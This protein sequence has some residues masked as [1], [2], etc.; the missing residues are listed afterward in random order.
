V[1][2]L[3]ALREWQP[4]SWLARNLRVKVLA[5]LLA[6]ASW[7]VVVY[8]ANPPDSRQ[9]LVHVQQDAQQLP[10]RYVLAH[11]ISDITVRIQGTR[12]HV[13]AFTASSIRATPNFE[14]IK[15]TGLQQLPVTVVNTDPNV[16]LTD[17]PGSVTADV[18]LLGATNAPVRVITSKS[19]AGYLISSATATPD[20]VQLI[21]PQRELSYAQA[22]VD[23]N[24]GAR[25]VTLSQ[26]LDVIAVDPRTGNRPLSDVVVRT[27]AGSGAE[28]TV[29]VKV[30]I[31]P[32]DG[33]VVSLV[34][35]SFSS[36]VAADHML[37]GFTVEPRTVTLTGA[38]NL[39]NGAQT[40]STAPIPL[41]D[42][43]TDHDFV[44]PLQV[45]AGLT[46]ALGTPGTVT[47]HVSVVTLP[48]AVVT[49]T[50]PSAPPASSSSSTTT[51]KSTTSGCTTTASIIRPTPC[52]TP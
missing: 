2:R 32:V 4:P 7:V 10:G 24:V 25:T 3:T 23:I 8:A 17:A 40:I 29:L 39:L 21:G 28:G 52:P 15:R 19:P 11:P 30:V 36:T 51:S 9:I 43:T 22:V 26:Q 6:L 18:D 50:G 44:V 31:T 1:R 5:S 12:E 37:S 46:L 35:P 20:H 27:G 16:E 45:P 41:S 49:P 13:D 33:S 42:L 14:A 38:E 34:V 48:R 47:V